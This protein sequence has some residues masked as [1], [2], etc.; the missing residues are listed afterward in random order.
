MTVLYFHHVYPCFLRELEATGLCFDL[1]D[2]LAC[3]LLEGFLL[4]LLGGF[5]LGG[6]LLG[7]ELGTTFVLL[8]GFELELEPRFEHAVGNELLEGW[9]P[10]P[11]GGYS[12]RGSVI[13]VKERTSGNRLTGGRA[14]LDLLRLFI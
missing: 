13:G 3:G 14:R 2:E 6:F 12:T 1:C 4:G 9:R 5:L 7:F 11:T 8:G 10:L